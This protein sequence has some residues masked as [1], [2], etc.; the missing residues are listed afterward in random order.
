M[1]CYCWEGP[2][3]SFCNQ[4]LGTGTSND[5]RSTTDIAASKSREFLGRHRTPLGVQRVVLCMH[6]PL[7]TDP[8]GT[9]ALYRNRRQAFYAV[10]QSHT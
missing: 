7:Q 8:L 5:V 4:A 1:D 3:P 10:D 6:V 9:C 2:G